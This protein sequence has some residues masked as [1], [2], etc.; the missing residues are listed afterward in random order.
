MQMNVTAAIQKGRIEMPYVHLK[1]GIALLLL[2]LSAEAQTPGS[3]TEQRCASAEYRQ[4][5]FWL[6]EWDVTQ[7]GK[8]AG[9]NSIRS[10]LNGCA[11]SEEWSGAGGFRG[12]SLNF[13]N[14]ESKR[15]HQTW[16]DSRG[17]SLLLDGQLDG[18]SMVLQSAGTEMPRHRITWTPMPDKTVRQF[19]QVQPVSGGEW[20]TLFDGRYAPRDSSK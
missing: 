7:S 20:K 15:W 3:V 9:R 2:A 11:I 12:T 16:I 6:G 8:V 13:Y 17:Q 5:D 14:A 10:I 19:W 4:F 1:I 18:G